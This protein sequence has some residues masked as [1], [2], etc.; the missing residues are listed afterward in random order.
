MAQSI[1]LQDC[2]KGKVLQTIPCTTITVGFNFCLSK[3]ES[4]FFIVFDPIHVINSE[5]MSSFSLYFIV[6]ASCLLLVS[7]TFIYSTVQYVISKIIDRI[8]VNHISIR[9]RCLQYLLSP[10]L[11][12]SW[13]QIRGSELDTVS[14]A[15]TSWPSS[16]LGKEPSR[17]IC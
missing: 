16:T 1:I 2:S 17:S 15:T 13:S 12:V 7:E 11:Q 3:S 5:K 8:L 4:I 10:A 9:L 14:A 6:L